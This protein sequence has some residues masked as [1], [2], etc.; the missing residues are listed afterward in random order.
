MTNKEFCETLS[1]LMDKWNEYRPKWIA[2]FGTDEGYGEWFYEQ[3]TG[4]R[5]G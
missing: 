1:E 4:R 2:H 3:A 5:I